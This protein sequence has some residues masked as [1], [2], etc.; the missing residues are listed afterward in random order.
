MYVIRR[1]NFEDPFDSLYNG[2]TQ[3][4]E[5]NLKYVSFNTLNQWRH[6]EY[7]MFISIV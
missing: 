5:L 4:S 1:F 3:N 6:V 7:I 2:K